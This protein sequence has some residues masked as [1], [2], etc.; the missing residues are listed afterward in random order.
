M[1]NTTVEIVV[2]ENVIGSV[3]G[4]NGSN[5]TRLRQVA[6]AVFLVQDSFTHHTK[7]IFVPCLVWFE[8]YVLSPS[9]KDFPPNQRGT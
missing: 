3:Y 4:E 2:P 6:L 7:M 8:I 5:L 1:T 9:E